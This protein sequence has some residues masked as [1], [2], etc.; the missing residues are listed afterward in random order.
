MKNISSLLMALIL[1]TTISTYLFFFTGGNHDITPTLS[2]DIKTA[3]QELSIKSHITTLPQESLS[4]PIPTKSTERPQ[5]L[6]HSTE[7]VSSPPITTSIIPQSREEEPTSKP[8]KIEQLLSP[9]K[10]DIHSLV[11]E[12]KSFYTEEEFPPE[13][14]DSNPNSSL[15]ET[16]HS[17]QQYNPQVALPTENEIFFFKYV[18]VSK[19]IDGD[20]IDVT[21]KNDQT[22]RVR[23]IGIDTPETKDPRKPVQCFGHEASAKAYE[24]LFDKQVMLSIPK[25]ESEDKYGRQLAYVQVNNLDYGAMMISEGYAYHYSRFPHNR[26]ELYKTLETQARDA[27]SGL[28]TSETCN[29]KASPVDDA[30]SNITPSTSLI[31]PATTCSCDTNTKNCSHFKRQPEAQAY[32]QCCM[33]KVGFD[34]HK[35]DGDGNGLVCESL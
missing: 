24:L 3:S 12:L 16:P 25:F 5:S 13:F 22:K 2:A 15:S 8:E 35:L 27:G 18:R 34:V 1:G 9:S 14:I 11:Q 7:Q 23:I 33:E 19:V 4:P 21:D 26:M 20:T 17:P 30:S 6:P 29:G 28:W 31:E 32:F 10:T